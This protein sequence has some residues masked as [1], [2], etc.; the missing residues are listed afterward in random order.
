MGNS[1]ITDGLLTS[2]LVGKSEGKAQLDRPKPRWRDRT[3]YYGL[4]LSGSEQGPVEG[5]CDCED[6]PL[7]SI[8]FW[9]L[10]E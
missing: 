5:S 10:L 3:G 9:E 6:E 7:G 2:I 4:D 8:K 1:R